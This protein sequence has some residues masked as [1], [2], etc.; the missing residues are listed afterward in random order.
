MVHTILNTIL[1]HQKLLEHGHYQGYIL[2]LALHPQKTDQ[3]N[4]LDN[5]NNEFKHSCTQ[6]IY[7][8][9]FNI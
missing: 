1:S 2:S 9:A 3:Q 6:E 5:F 8:I 7:T 4:I